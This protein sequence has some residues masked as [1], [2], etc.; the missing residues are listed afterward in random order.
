MITTNL[1]VSVLVMTNGVVAGK[2]NLELRP[3]WGERRIVCEY[4]KA[5]DKYLKTQEE[6]AFRPIGII[7]P[8]GECHCKFVPTKIERYKLVPWVE[9]KKEAVTRSF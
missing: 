2:H 7:P 6:Y 8:K 5:Y 1:V 4:C 9:P 3:V